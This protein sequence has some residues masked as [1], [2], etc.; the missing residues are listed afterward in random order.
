MRAGGFAPILLLQPPFPEQSLAAGGS[1][2]AELRSASPREGAVPPA[3]PGARF[4]PASL[5]PAR[6]GGERQAGGPGAARETLASQD[7]AGLAHACF[8]AAHSRPQLNRVLASGAGRWGWARL[9][10]SPFQGCS[11]PPRCVGSSK[12]GA[13]HCVVHPSPSPAAH[14]GQGMVGG[15]SLALSGVPPTPVPAYM[16]Q[17]LRSR[18]PC[19]SLWLPVCGGCGYRPSP[20]P[21]PSSRIAWGGFSRAWPRSYRPTSLFWG[22]AL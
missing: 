22:P 7:W 13:P 17:L 10:L 19:F 15:G 20:G 11:A 5:A 18:G 14:S 6:S 3:C 21:S 9:G 16:R 12:P 2:G 8:V 4:P 1:V